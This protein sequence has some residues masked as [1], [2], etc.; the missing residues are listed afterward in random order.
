MLVPEI[1][2]NEAL[3]T[4]I[5]STPEECDSDDEDGTEEWEP[6]VLEVGMTEANF[7]KKNLGPGDAIIISA[8]LTHKDKGAMTS[9]NLASNYLHA[10]GAKIIAEAIKVI[11]CAIAVVL[12]PFSYSS[13][14]WLNCYCLLLSAEYGGPIVGK[15]PPEQ[16]WHR[17]G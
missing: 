14:Q 15:P 8:W 10:D 17:P 6:A 12:A 4:L 1:I 2:D 9:L 5:F 11:K 16:H 3:S 13:D 7:S